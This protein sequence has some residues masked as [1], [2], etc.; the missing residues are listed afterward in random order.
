MRSYDPSFETE[1]AEFLARALQSLYKSIEDNRRLIEIAEHELQQKENMA[2]EIEKLIGS[3]PPRDA[4][5]DNAS[6]I[7]LYS[8]VLQK[9]REYMLKK[10]KPLNRREILSYLLSEGVALDVSDPAHFVGKV[11][12]RSDDFISFKEGYWPA[13]LPVPLGASKS[14]RRK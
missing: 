13:D 12:W 11:L 3:K 1:S 7:P 9:A 2:S 6:R 4:G 10:A 5:K 8:V 14:D